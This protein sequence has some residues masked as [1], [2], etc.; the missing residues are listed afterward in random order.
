[1][2]R[3]KD[4]CLNF[5]QKLRLQIPDST[6][7]PVFQ[8]WY[9]EARFRSKSKETIAWIGVGMGISGCRTGVLSVRSRTLR[10]LLK[11]RFSET[12]WAITTNSRCACLLIFAF[13]SSAHNR[14]LQLRSVVAEN[15]HPVAFKTYP[16]RS[17]DREFTWEI[18]TRGR[19]VVLSEILNPFY[20]DRHGRSTIVT[21]GEL[22]P[23]F[24]LSPTQFST[25]RPGILPLRT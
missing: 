18:P 20:T 7:H 12:G 6:P 4:G 19:R 23:D 8:R 9:A 10:V 11:N 1:M 24:T 3:R 5:Q 2:H 15:K 16:Y 13:F 22:R 14:G 17:T 25:S 21:S